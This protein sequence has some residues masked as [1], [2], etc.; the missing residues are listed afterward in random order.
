M[1]KRIAAMLLA[2][3]MIAGVF[4]GCAG[5]PT[6]TTP[7]TPASNSGTANSG[8]T[9]TTK[10]ADNG[11]QQ[12]APAEEAIEKEAPMLAAQVKDGK[13]PPLEE[14]IPTVE[15]VYVE[16]KYS[17]EETPSYGGVVRTYNN[18]MW[19]WGPFCEEPLFRL[20]DDG[21]VESNVA[22]G[23]DLSDDGLVYTI[24]LREGMKWSDGTPFTATDCVYYYN[25][26][27]VTDVDNE[28][29]KITKSNAGRNYGWY[30]T[31]DENGILR[32]AQVR[33]V[34]D[35]TFTITLYSPKPTLLQAICI[36]N[37]WMFCPKEWYK[38]IMVNDASAP[39][40]SGETDLKLIGGE[41]LPTI[42]EEEALANALK[43]SELYNFENF[44]KLGDQLGYRYWQYAGRPTLRPWNIVNALTDQTLVFE[45]NPYYWKVDK[46]G[47]QL[48]YIDTVEFV[49][50]DQNLWAQEEIAGNIDV[51]RF[52]AGD[53]PIY[54]ASEAVGNYTVYTEI[55]P[56]W[57]SVG[58]EL[59][60]SYKDLQYRALFQNI[61]FRH[62]LSIAAD[63]NEINEIIGNGMMT[64]AQFAAPEGTGDYIAG[65]P[66]KWV[67]Y[68]VAAA[69]KLL[70][71][72]EG[73]SKELNADGFRTF[74]GGEHDGQAITIELE[75]R[76]NAPSDAQLVALLAKY[77]KALGLQIVESNNTDN[78]A[79]NE[80]YYAGDI[81]MG[82][83]NSS[84]GSFNV[85]LR[86]DAVAANR[87]NSAF[88]GKYGLE[89]QDALTPEP[90]TG[91]A[92]LIDATKALVSANKLEELQAASKRIAQAHYDNTWVIGFCVSDRTY[93]AV[94]NRVHN[95]RSG[96]VNCDELRFLGYTKPYT[97]FIQD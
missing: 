8:N 13:L 81:F 56:S 53:F 23:Y 70:D 21:T 66:Q 47:R 16:A 74:V 35:L 61:D 3:V 55:S 51:A 15:D 58:L 85:M 59:N 97:W 24:H 38:D 52:D 7:T 46:D 37:K 68:D 2:L 50:M 86:P 88:V 42:T 30:K 90:G 73:I 65:A 77:Y 34:D 93:D 18:G 11:N 45:R 69:N 62:A 1:K 96:F 83:V 95:F 84:S 76:A 94:N 4:A 32:P 6:A 22:K 67:E 48:P 31:T 9:D 82:A 72:I 25:Y 79:R 44:S 92:E 54:K 57:S 60:Q 27:L 75:T 39:H 5:Q 20:L 29:G 64:P 49:G 43:K 10:P 26:V 89:H 91:L 14:R 40:W 12:A 33:Y 41:G 19:Y 71:G 87:N 78:N 63:R 36:D 17:P 80:R 28:T